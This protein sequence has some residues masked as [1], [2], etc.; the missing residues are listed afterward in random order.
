MQIFLKLEALALQ[1]VYIAVAPIIVWT[2][3]T[4]KGYP[5]VA[6]ARA[7][8]Y[9]NYTAPAAKSSVVKVTFKIFYRSWEV[10]KTLS[11]DLV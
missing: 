6:V 8:G 3:M 10:G 2:E 1:H 9:H 4:V 5:Y 11:N 7:G